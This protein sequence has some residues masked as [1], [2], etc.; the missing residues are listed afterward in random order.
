MVSPVSINQTPKLTNASIFYV[1]DEHSQIDNMERLKTAADSFDAFV[2]SEKTDKLKFSQGDFALGTDKKL[3][4]LAVTAQNIMGIMATAGGNHDFDLRKK[5][6]LEVLNNDYKLLGINVEIPQDTPENKALHD[7]VAKSYIQ[8]VNGTKYGVIGLMPFDFHFHVSDQ[9]EYSDFQTLSIP[10]TVVTLQREVDNLQKQGINKI[11]LLS[12]AGYD[13][14]IVMAQAVEGID[15][16]LG[17]HSHDL[18]KGIQEGKNLFYSKKTGAPTL[19]TQA[20]KDGKYFGVLNLQFDENG[21]IKTAQNNVVET[22]IFPKSLLMKYYTDKI[23]GKPKI[24]GRINSVQEDRISLIKESASANFINDITRSELNVDISIINSGNMRG[25]F[26][27]G[28]LTDRD[29]EGIIP[30]KNKVGIV[31]ITEKEL[32]D[33]IKVGAQSV[34]DNNHHPGFL[35][36]SGIKYSLNKSGEVKEITYVDKEG[37]ETPIDVNNPDKNKTYKVA[38]DDFIAKGG[39]EYFSPD[40]WDNAEKQFDFDKIKLAIDYIQKLNKPI[41][42]KPD[43]RIKVID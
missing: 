39:N 8:E 15:V 6:L 27:V 22:D 13:A 20:G 11:I 36:F 2:P 5:P 42:I 24:I 7:K 26:E 41:D 38:M 12:H 1:N 4:A 14:D 9:Q 17:G 19:I 25:I 30:F 32:V 21:V 37:K 16:I 34:N 10:Q 3:N 18:I 29:M 28:P 35:Q 40:K 43:S 23:L 33:A 31:S